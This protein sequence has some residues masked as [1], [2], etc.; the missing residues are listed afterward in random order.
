[1]SYN[2]KVKKTFVLIVILLFALAIFSLGRKYFKPTNLPPA[3][4]TVTNSPDPTALREESKVSVVAQNL[5]VPWALAFLPDGRLLITER[6]GSVKILDKGIVRLVSEISEVSQ[7]GESGLHGIAVH[8]NFKENQ[9]VYAYYTYSSSDGNNKN[10]V[11]RFKLDE[12]KLTEDK[13]ILDEIPAASNHDG[14]RIKFGPDGLLYITTGDA[15]NPSLSQNKTSLAG[16][17]LRLTDE[18]LIPS[19]NPFGNSVYSYGH[20]NPQGLAWDD[21]GNLWETEHGST[22]TD[23]LN[24]SKLGGNCG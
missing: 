24:K 18:G 16:K 13:I 14:G 12:N 20:R 1:M 21:K 6:R 4:S 9:Y 17:I 8:P 5:E 3:R 2:R 23:E 22:A 11:V 15:S 7:I 10:R 19:S